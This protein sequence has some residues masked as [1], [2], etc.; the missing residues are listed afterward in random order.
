MLGEAPLLISSVSLL[1]SIVT[2]ALVIQLVRNSRRTLRLTERRVN[3][4]REEQERL[5]LLREEHQIL[6]QALEQEIL[7]R[8]D[9]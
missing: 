6:R 8:V 9:E 5:A 7:M 2:L 3:Y 4:L 1:V